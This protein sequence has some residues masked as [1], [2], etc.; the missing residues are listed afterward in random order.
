VA[1][2]VDPDATAMGAPDGITLLKMGQPAIVVGLVLVQAGVGAGWAVGPVPPLSD[3]SVKAAVH[4]MLWMVRA[5]TAVA[6]SVITHLAWG[7]V[8]PLVL[9]AVVQ[10]S[11]LLLVLV[12]EAVLVQRHVVPLGHWNWVSLGLELS[13]VATR[14]SPAA[15]SASYWC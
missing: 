5:W 12:V 15:R 6:E 1:A 3:P 8:A 2:I 4:P 11:L 14:N 13:F 10:L 9:P 7:G